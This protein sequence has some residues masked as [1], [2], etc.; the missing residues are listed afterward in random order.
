[1]KE[2]TIKEIITASAVFFI[3]LAVGLLLIHY[4]TR[5]EKKRIERE[6][7]S[8]WP[9]ANNEFKGLSK[10]ELDELMRYDETEKFY[11]N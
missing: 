10:R 7:K 1:M 6:Y 5:K 8:R 2:V 11:H 9:S 4:W 3:I